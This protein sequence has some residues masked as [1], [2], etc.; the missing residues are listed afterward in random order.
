LNVD[1]EEYDGVDVDVRRRRKEDMSS[2]HCDKISADL[3]P[4]P[5]R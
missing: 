1:V 2:A 3:G 5:R 4:E